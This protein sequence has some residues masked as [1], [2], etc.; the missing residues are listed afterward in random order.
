MQI[1]TAYGQELVLKQNDINKYGHAIECRI[2]A[3]DPET[4]IPSPG[5]VT[6]Y[7][8]PGGIGIRVDSH[9]YAGYTVS[10]YYDALIAKICAFSFDRKSAIKRMSFAL[11]EF[12]VDGI[13]TNKDLQEIIMKEPNFFEGDISINYLKEVLNIN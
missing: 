8:P 11:E 12:F 13:S 3:E 2:N 10:P 5:K 9:L 1:E 7:D 6:E 4:F